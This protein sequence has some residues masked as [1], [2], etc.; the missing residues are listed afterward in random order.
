MATALISA[1]S[2]RAVRGDVAMTGEITL[3]GNI[4]AIGG[5]NEKL[6]AA[7]RAG[8]KDVIIPKENERDIEDIKDEIK[9][10]LNIIPV[11]HISQA[12]EIAIKQ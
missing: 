6:L 12:V 1:A 10:G 7:K 5:L 8:I 2:G 3:R 4:L 11:S 9:S